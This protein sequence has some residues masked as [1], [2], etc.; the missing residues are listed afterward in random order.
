LNDLNLILKRFPTFRALSV[1]DVVQSTPD[2]NSN[3]SDQPVQLPKMKKLNILLR[4]GILPKIL[5]KIDATLLIGSKSNPHGKSA[6]PRSSEN[7][8]NKC[9]GLK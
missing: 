4:F 3:P 2:D 8:P 9:L 6:S 1:T 5:K 7:V